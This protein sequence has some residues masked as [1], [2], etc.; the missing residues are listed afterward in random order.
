MTKLL[1]LFLSLNLAYAAE[2]TGWNIIGESSGCDH[3]LSIKAK[4]GEKSIRVLAG[5]KEYVLFPEG[6]YVFMKNA[7]T[8]LVYDSYNRKGDQQSEVRYLYTHSSVSAGGNAEGTIRV[9]SP[10]QDQTCKIKMK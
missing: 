10:R 6:N 7:P 4:E 1:F 2:S 9:R 3:K 8:T 5:G